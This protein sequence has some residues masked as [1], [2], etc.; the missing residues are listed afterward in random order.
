MTNYRIKIIPDQTYIA[1]KKG[2]TILGVYNSLLNAKKAAIRDFGYN[3]DK[4]EM[5]IECSE[6]EY[7]KMVFFVKDI[8][9]EELTNL[10]DDTK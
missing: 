5:T 1:L 7:E 10:G 2:N 3:K 4:S 8:D 9:L 6:K